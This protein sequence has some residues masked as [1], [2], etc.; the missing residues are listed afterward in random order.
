[1]RDLGVS[2]RQTFGLVSR[3]PR[4]TRRRLRLFPSILNAITVVKLET[5]ILPH[6]LKAVERFKMMLVM[7]REATG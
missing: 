3:R 2:S 4:A 5:V 6:A 1:V 7:I